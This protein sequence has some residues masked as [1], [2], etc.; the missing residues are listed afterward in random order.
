MSHRALWI[1]LLASLSF[2]VACGG[3][4]S[5]GGSPTTPSPNN[6]VTTPIINTYTGSVSFRD[7]AGL[8]VVRAAGSLVGAQAVSPFDGLLDFLVLRLNAQ[9]STATGA[10]T[11]ADGTTIPLT[12]THAAGTFQLSGGGYSADVTVS[13]GALAGSVS[14]PAGPASVTPLGAAAAVPAPDNP[15]GTYIGSYEI[16]AAGYHIVKAPSGAVELNC[17]RRARITG[18]VT[19]RIY[20]PDASPGTWAANIRDDWSESWSNEGTCPPEIFQGTVRPQGPVGLDYTGTMEAIQGTFVDQGTGSFGQRLVRTH[21]FLGSVTGQTIQARV[22][23]TFKE[24]PSTVNNNR[25][26]E[27]GYPLSSTTFTLQKQN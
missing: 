7:G 25:T 4:E 8:L 23:K 3:S 5:G 16:S 20:V 19:A 15:S 18:T 6:P 1:P 2:A 17:L 21:T 27:G 13:N 11:L 9:G 12:G 24:G 10:L 14:T 22:L 26:A